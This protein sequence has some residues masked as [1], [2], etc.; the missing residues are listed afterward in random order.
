MSTAGLTAAIALMLTF[1][2]CRG[3]LDLRDYQH[4]DGSI[5]VRTGVPFGD[6][7]FPTKALIVAH[8]AG[9]D[10]RAPALAWID[11][12]RARQ[13]P[14]GRFA[15]YCGGPGTWTE[16]AEEDA[17][18]AM[19]AVWMQLLYTM[20]PSD[21]LPGEW[22]ATAIAAESYLDT[23]RDPS[24]GVYRIS[25]AQPTAL[26][27]DNVEVYAALR[28]SAAAW[29]RYGDRGHAGRLAAS[30]DALA[31]AIERTFRTG[32]RKEYR[33]S[34]Q[35]RSTVEF[36]PDA[37]AQTYPWLVSFPPHQ[38]EHRR[39][40]RSWLRK[41]RDQWTSAELDYPWGLV[42]L[43]AAKV[44]ERDEAMAWRRRAAPLRN[45]IRWN[46]LEEAAFQSLSRVGCRNGTSAVPQ[47]HAG[48]S[49]TFP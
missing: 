19:L 37:V 7:Y 29:H 16:C 9:L 39:E 25:R 47:P 10:V 21:R 1:A 41:Y 17:D 43:T 24:S 26:F 11:W 4:S 33:V 49:P 31:L 35:T 15:R 18:D 14:D 22:I 44:G 28:E 42:A 30:A 8:D 32:G 36:Y 45:T 34:T 5:T 23:I 12:L 3:M 48:S 2:P 13:R 27:I 6:P 20:S 40:F 46:V 38:S